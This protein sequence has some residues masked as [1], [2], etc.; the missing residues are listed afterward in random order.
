[1]L[2]F[3]AKKAYPALVTAF[4]AKKVHALLCLCWKETLTVAHLQ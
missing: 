4:P 1:M 2:Y 3:V